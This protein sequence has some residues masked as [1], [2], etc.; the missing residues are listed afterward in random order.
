[1]NKSNIKIVFVVIFTFILATNN[2]TA[3]VGIGTTN[4]AASSMLEIQST[5]KGIL[6]PRMTSVQR[7]AISSPANSLLVFD[8]DTQS[9]WFYNSGWVELATGAPDKII[10]AEGDTRVE[11]EQSAD[12]DEINFTT[13]GIERMKIDANGVIIMGDSTAT[14]KN[15]TKITTD[16]SLSYV[17]N[18]TRWEDLRVPTTSLKE[19]DV[20]MPKWDVFI[21]DAG[22]PGVYLHWFDDQDGVTDKEEELFF[23]AQMP[24]GWKEGSDIKPHVHWTTKDDATGK[25]VEW[26]LQYVW[27]NVTQQFSSTT[28]IIYTN[29]TIGTPG[30]RQHL[31]STFP[32]IVGTGHTLSSMLICRLFRHSS[33]ANDTFDGKEA[34]LIEIDFHYQ[35][36]SDGSNEEY[37]KW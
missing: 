11:V 32:T 31:I 15:Y 23:T 8:T 30:I 7:I 20:D 24:H 5:S 1:M 22:G 28:T 21:D 6:I 25:N 9:F 19:R 35:I 33:H 18:A 26:G 36:D 37:L 27:A 12:V 16:G 4:P 29:N 3:Q 13:S 2:I 14:S 34:G 10:N 17:G